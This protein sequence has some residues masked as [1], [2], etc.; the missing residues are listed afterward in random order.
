MYLNEWLKFSLHLAIEDEA[1]R[2]NLVSL[3]FNF[4]TDIKYS[5][6]EYSHLL[7]PGKLML[8]ESI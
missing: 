4:M 5:Y 8:K 1:T 3:M 2:S 6:K 7:K